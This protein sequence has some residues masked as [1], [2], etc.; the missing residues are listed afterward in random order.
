MGEY[1]R[2]VAI[3]DGGSIHGF[4]NGKTYTAGTSQ[5]IYSKKYDASKVKD[6]PRLR[7]VYNIVDIITNK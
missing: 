4:L 7:F 5:A 6:N 3:D 1:D 2:I